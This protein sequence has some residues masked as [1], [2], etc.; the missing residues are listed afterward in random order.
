M[1]NKIFIIGLPR[2]GTTSVCH[3][4]LELGVATAHTAYTQQ[5]FEKATALA[6]TPIFNDYQTL[7]QYYPN[8]KFIYLERD[9]NA[10]LPS[11]KQLL[12]RMHTNLT[13][14]DGG[15]NIHIKRCYLNTFKA[16]SIDKI[17]DDEYLTSCYQKHFNDAQA[18]FN[19]RKSDFLSINIA[20]QP[21]YQRLC[22]FLSLQSTRNDF[23]KLNIGG[24]VTAWNDIKH[25][26]KIASTAKGRIDKCL[27][28]T[29]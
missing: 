22:E 1:N 29:I 26:L 5:C 9:L 4:L 7:D 10:W 11:I 6:D 20:Q 21:S 3:A 28:Y 17:N 15:F 25:P 8:A 13:R 27:P 19:N 14:T 12:L 16:L 24:K 2:T 18:Y 23:E